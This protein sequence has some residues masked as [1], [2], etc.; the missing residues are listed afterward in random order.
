MRCDAH[1]DG[2]GVALRFADG[3]EWWSGIT[4]LGPTPHYPTVS[5]DAARAL[6]LSLMAV[7]PVEIGIARA[8]D[9]RH[10]D[11]PVPPH[12]DGDVLS[13]SSSA[14][15]CRRRRPAVS[16][17]RRAG[18]QVGSAAGDTCPYRRAQVFARRVVGNEMVARSVAGPAHRWRRRATSTVLFAMCF[19]LR[20]ADD[21]PILFTTSTPTESSRRSG[22]VQYGYSYPAGTAF[23]FQCNF[24]SGYL[25]P[26]M[27]PTGTTSVPGRRRSGPGRR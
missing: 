20:G 24:E 4:S 16:L 1:R 8:T 7:R 5:V 18:R 22:G 21:P 3:G 26:P 13:S 12:L 6:W 11:Y 2:V 15:P 17:S 10:L 19:T 23:T 14:R 25:N 9:T 27:T